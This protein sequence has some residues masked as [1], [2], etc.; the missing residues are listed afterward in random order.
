MTRRRLLSFAFL[1][2]SLALAATGTWKGEH[3]APAPASTSVRPLAVAPGGAGGQGGV[4]DAT[5]TAGPSARPD[6][7]GSGGT[8]SGRRPGHDGGGKLPPTDAPGSPSSPPAT[9]PPTTA[10]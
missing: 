4:V 1:A 9:A 7:P 8:P 3:G 10:T 5:P 2:C 6:A